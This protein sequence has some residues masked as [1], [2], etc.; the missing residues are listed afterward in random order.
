MFPQQ[1]EIEVPLLRALAA[2]GGEARAKDVYEAVTKQFRQLTDSDLSQTLP[3]GSNKWTN[4]I[5]WARQALV[6]KGELTSAGHGV[7]SITARGRDKIVDDR[8]AAVESSGATGSPIRSGSPD[9]SNVSPGEDYKTD[10]AYRS[11]LNLEDVSDDYR[12]SFKQKV[13]NKLLDIS[14]AQFEKFA[15]TL[16]KGYGFQK[17]EVTGKTGDGG[18]DGHRQLRVGLAVIRAAFQCKRWQNS[19]G[20]KEVRGFR[21]A[22]QGQYEQG[23]FFT[24]STFTKSAQQESIKMRAV[25][26]ILFEGDQIVEIMIERGVGI[27]R[28]PI[29]LYEDQLE[30]LFE[31]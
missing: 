16:L 19:V 3:S 22:I 31:T 6:S 23:Y 2:L 7:W 17:T 28:R 15:E 5:Q 10:P 27:K 13:L 18:I 12:V 20:P 26:G 21:G 4:H 8:E 11:N 9:D 1:W 29:E 24:T 30:E 25:P 14:P